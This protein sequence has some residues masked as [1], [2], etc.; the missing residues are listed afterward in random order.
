MDCTKI[1]YKYVREAVEHMKWIRKRPRG[2]KVPDRV[3]LCPE[4]NAYH[5]TSSPKHD[6]AS[7]L[8][9]AQ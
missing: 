5:L 3:Y 6:N 7:S 2:R 4:C 9:A 8:V 1:S